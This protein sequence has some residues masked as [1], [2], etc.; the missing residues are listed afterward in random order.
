[1][2]VIDAC[3]FHEWRSIRDLAPYMTEGWR[4]T[5]LRPG[6]PTGPQPPTTPLYRHPTGRQDPDAYPE[7]GPAGSDAEQFGRQLLADGRRDRVVLGYDEAGLL[8]TAFTNS[9]AG[10]TLVAAINDWT[11][12]TWLSDDSR[13]AGLI[14]VSMDDP[15]RA[16]QE[17]ERLGD[18]PAFCGVALGT[19]GLSIPFGHKVY[20]PVIEAAAAHDLPIVL[21]AGSD[22]SPTLLAQPVA[23]GVAA[24]YAE[25]QVWAA[26]PLMTHVNSLIF[27]GVFELFPNLKAVVVGGGVSWLPAATWRMDFW[28]SNNRLE[29]PLLQRV[30][31]EYLRHHVRFG[32][33]DIEHPADPTR[34]SR[35]LQTVP[36]L[37]EV[38]MYASGYPNVSWEEP[39]AVLARLP[40]EWS[41][42]VGGATAA[43]TFRF[44][45]NA[46]AG[47]TAPSDAVG[48]QS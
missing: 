34:L 39:D 6:S 37:S 3:A 38:I 28:W 16:A 40:E 10:N 13:L 48:A 32:A 2:T 17:V 26:H 46:T 12:D 1:M 15:Q 33:S 44:A 45:D 7:K 35:A 21:Q 31:S 30:P 27:E 19:N 14:L 8:A 11:R 22:T 47:R 18:D 43:A 24:T 41:E 29:A 23:G 36:W 25:T 9:A 20:R 5:F 42:A 4:E